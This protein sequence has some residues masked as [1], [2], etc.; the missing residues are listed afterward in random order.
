M[1]ILTKIRYLYLGL[2]II[3]LGPAAL[4]V[5]V[6]WEI[7]QETRRR[8][9]KLTAT[10]YL[11]LAAGLSLML[12]GHAGIAWWQITCDADMSLYPAYAQIASMALID[13]AL[14]MLMWISW[15]IRREIDQAQNR[16]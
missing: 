6:N 10:C 12:V 15:M 14:I 11:V 1:S 5:A 4:L 2:G 3:G 16:F 7:M 8:M 13:L 9:E